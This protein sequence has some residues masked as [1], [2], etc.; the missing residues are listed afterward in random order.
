V[1]PRAD[2]AIVGGGPVGLYLALALLQEGVRPRV[3]ERHA[4]VRHAGSRSIGVHP[5]SI[6]LFEEIGVAD[7]FLAQAVRV[8]R[9]IAFGERGPVGDVSFDGCPGPHRFV[10]TLEQWKTEALLRGALLARAPD[11]LRTGCEVASARDEGERATLWLRRADGSLEDSSYAAIVGTDGRRSVVR[12]ALGIA[13]DGGTYEGEYAMADAPE[14]TPFGDAAA[15]FLTRGGLVES[16]PLPDGRRRWVV[17]RELAREGTPVDP[18]VTRDEIADLVAA[19]TREELPRHLLTA[20]TTFR[21]E[22]RLA[23]AFAVGRVALAGDAAH[24]VSPI[25]G[26][27]MNLGWLGA[28]SLARALGPALA[29]GRDPRRALALDGRKRRAIAQTARRR[30]EMNMWLGRPTSYPAVRERLVG[31][32]LALPTADVLARAFTMRSLDRGI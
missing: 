6:E 17:R 9:G 22:H 12:Q 5:P 7:D 2:V 30:A 16:F 25:G 32:L 26:Q 28:R 27:G 31:T 1:T 10:A 29:A 11:A 4:S 20:P 21:A 3:Y 8:R 14:T 15:V 24:V 23:R 19:R 13:F 18:V